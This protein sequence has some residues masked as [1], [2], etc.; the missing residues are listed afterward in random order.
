MNFI[1]PTNEISIEDE[2]PQSFEDTIKDHLSKFEDNTD[3][4]EEELKE[5]K[6]KSFTSKNDFNNSNTSNIEDTNS[7]TEEE[8]EEV[9]ETNTEFEDYIIE[10]NKEGYIRKDLPEGVEAV[11]DLKTYTQILK[12]NHDLDLK[13]LKQ[14]TI[15][16]VYNNL[17]DDLDPFTKQVLSFALDKKTKGGNVQNHAKALLYTVDVYNLDTEDPISQEEIIRE[18]QRFKTDDEKEIQDYIDLIKD[19]PEKLKQKAIEFK[20][21]LVE[22]SKKEAMK[23][24]DNQKLVEQEETERKSYFTNKLIDQLQKGLIGD[25]PISKEEAGWLYNASVDDTIPVK[26]KGQKTNMNAF[27]Y[28]GHFHKYNEQGDINLYLTALMLMKDPAKVINHFN[29]LGKKAAV[30]ELRSDNNFA[31][32]GGIT[33]NKSKKSEPVKKKEISYLDI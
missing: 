32:S 17:K 2:S 22:L 9:D 15:E 21:K 4:I 1:K 20:P 12:Y 25:I 11:T 33:F 31:N 28:L 13:Q 27:D 24:I 3:L 30:K 6:N 14:F 7:N 19:N 16:E 26:I 29:S 23:E 5:N 10:L 8:T 18:Y